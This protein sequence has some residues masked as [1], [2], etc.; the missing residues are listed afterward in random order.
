MGPSVMGLNF[1]DHICGDHTKTFHL[2][3]TE[4]EFTRAIT[5]GETVKSKVY[6]KTDGRRM[7][8]RN[9]GDFMLIQ[10]KDVPSICTRLSYPHSALRQIHVLVCP[11]PHIFVLNLAYATCFELIPNLGRYPCSH[12]GDSVCLLQ[13]ASRHL[14][15]N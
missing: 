12:S 13:K 5:F 11:Q 2:L 9:K 1:T 14:S 10:G 3:I 6:Q 8:S 7:W 15:I 4:E